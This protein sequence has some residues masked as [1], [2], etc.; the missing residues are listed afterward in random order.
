MKLIVKQDT[1]I[2]VLAY[3]DDEFID[4][5]ENQINIGNPISLVIFKSVDN[6][7]LIENALDAPEDFIGEKYLYDDSTEEKWA[8][9]PDYVSPLSQEEFAAKLAAEEAVEPA[10]E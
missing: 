8:L 5:L 1:N 6:I 10:P 7:C 2:V 4:D 3:S 9:N